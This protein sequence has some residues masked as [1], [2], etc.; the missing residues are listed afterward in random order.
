MSRYDRRT[1]QTRQVWIWPQEPHAL[2]NA[3]MKYREQWNS[4]IRFS[5]HDAGVLYHTS[6]FVHVTRNEGQTWERVSPDLTRWEEHKQLHVDPPGGPLTYDQTGV[7]VY[8][9]VF[10]FEE[11]PLQRGL[12]WA[13]SDDGAV[14][15]S[16]DGGGNWRDVT[17]PGMALHTTVT[18][19]IRI[20]V[21]VS[22]V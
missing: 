10:A 22:A 12:L 14:H 15:V 4:Q 19:L 6:Q 16:R 3:D 9:T 8:G 2:P 20:A 1:G 18:I 11:S 21:I 17:P 13:G 7:E 5:P